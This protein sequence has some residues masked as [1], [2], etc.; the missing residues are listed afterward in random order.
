MRVGRLTVLIGFSMWLVG[1]ASVSPPFVPG[2]PIN[3]DEV[4]HWLLPVDDSW[5]TPANADVQWQMLYNEHSDGTTW[6]Q[7]L[8]ADGREVWRQVEWIF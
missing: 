5:D 7:G 1:C 2:P 8:H 4:T 3:P 6:E